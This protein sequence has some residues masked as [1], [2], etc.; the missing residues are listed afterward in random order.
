MS[1]R[2]EFLVLSYPDMSFIINRDQLF[3]SIF[4]EESQALDCDI[5]YLYA[6]M[7]YLNQN[8][9]IFDL[10]AFIKNVFNRQN[11]STLNVAL[12]AELE[13][14]SPENQKSYRKH[15][16]N[17]FKNFSEKYVALKVNVNAV[18]K[19]IGLSEVRLIPKSLL[20]IQEKYGILGC[21]FTKDNYI[22]YWLD[23]ETIIINCIKRG[24]V[25]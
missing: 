15:V 3:A 7:A 11:K 13:S 14:F 24:N 8:L 16:L 2:H 5:Q 18:I 20:D 17:K 19:S 23:F 9:P 4:L 6:Q 21:R 12:V 10:E 22:Q 1:N 25:K